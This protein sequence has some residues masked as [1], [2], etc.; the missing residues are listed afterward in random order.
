MMQFLLSINA[1]D[2]SSCVTARNIPK[3]LIARQIFVCKK[4]F[5]MR[6]SMRIVQ[7]E[8]KTMKTI[9]KICKLLTFLYRT[10]K[11]HASITITHS[12]VYL[13]LKS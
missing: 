6:N 8:R 7:S 10:F 9:D 2:A 13:C 11:T 4:Q 1:D 5:Q 3:P 12:Y